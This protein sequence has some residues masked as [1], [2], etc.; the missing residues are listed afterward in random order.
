MRTAGI[1][2]Q[3]LLTCIDLASSSFFLAGLLSKLDKGT[4]SSRDS[5]MAMNARLAEYQACTSQIDSA[6][7][8]VWWSSYILVGF[9]LAGWA[10]VI[11]NLDAVVSVRV[12]DKGVP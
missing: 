6:R 7:D 11:T 12:V 9:A 5:E 4:R 2:L 10:L 3:T 8:A 1:L